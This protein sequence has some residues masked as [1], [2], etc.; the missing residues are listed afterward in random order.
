MFSYF[1]VQGVVLLVDVEEVEGVVA[2]VLFLQRSV[3]VSAHLF[4]CF[5]SLNIKLIKFM[6]QLLIIIKETVFK[7]GA[8]PH[9][10]RPKNK[11]PQNYL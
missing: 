6:K 4:I 1:N 7:M 2:A 10:L 11:Q 3:P 8:R 9:Y 5:K